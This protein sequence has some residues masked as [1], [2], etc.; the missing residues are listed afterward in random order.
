MHSNIILASPL[1][2]AN[3]YLKHAPLLTEAAATFVSLLYYLSS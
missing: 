1:Y 3:I 2:A